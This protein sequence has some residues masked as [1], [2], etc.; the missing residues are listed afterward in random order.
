V[1]A[2][3]V[4]H[5][6]MR[7]RQKQR[8]IVFFTFILPCGDASFLGHKVGAT[9]VQQLSVLLDALVKADAVQTIPLRSNN[10]QLEELRVI[11]RLPVEW[12]GGVGLD[13]G[14]QLRDQ[15]CQL[16]KHLPFTH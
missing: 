7:A 13:R 14:A 4:Q 5:R 16:V 8:A 15:L 9:T 6:V 2:G 11:W 12:R 10:P 3:K 1:S